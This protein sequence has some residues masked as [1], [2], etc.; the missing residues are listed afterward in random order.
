M[1]AVA[2]HH[3]QYWHVSPA[4]QLATT[5]AEQAME[6]LLDELDPTPAQRL[7]VGCDTAYLALQ[8][9]L[10]CGASGARCC[11]MLTGSPV[12]NKN[13]LMLFFLLWR[14]VFQARQILMA[15]EA[16]A[17]GSR[18]T[19]GD[20]DITRHFGAAEVAVS[21]ITHVVCVCMCVHVCV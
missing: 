3:L 16:A 13:G 15:A 5:D 7:R 2:T 10:P 9:S 18:L 8:H 12:F 20:A 4:V 21:R 14:A 1:T 19:F 6:D 17:K 11:S